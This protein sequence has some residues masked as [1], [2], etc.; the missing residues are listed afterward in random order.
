MI[1]SLRIGAGKFKGHRLHRPKGLE[2]IHISDRVREAAFGLLEPSRGLGVLD[3]FAGSGAM[4]LEA[5]SRGVAGHVT[6]IEREPAAARA[7]HRNLDS[8]HLRAPEVRVIREGPIDALMSPYLSGR[9]DIVI[10]A[11]P[12]A[13]FAELH[14]DLGQELHRVLWD[15]ALVLV[16]T[17]SK[18]KPELPLRVATSSTCESARLTLFVT[19]PHSD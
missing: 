1:A 8:L 14:A 19:E 16:V 13:T 7:I 5:L 6:F 15:E 12:P 17:D 10:V 4:G 9:W 3:L 2:S 18:V 11:P